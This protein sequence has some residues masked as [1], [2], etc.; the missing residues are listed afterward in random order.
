M[1]V[2]NRLQYTL[3]CLKSFSKQTYKD[4]EITIYDSGSTDGTYETISKIYPGIKLF[5]GDL[6]VWDNPGLSL[7]IDY[8]KSI[9]QPGDYILVQN[10]DTV[11]DPD[12]VQTLVT[13]SKS[14]NRSIVGA[15]TK[16]KNTGKVIFHVSKLIKHLYQ[17]IILTG[18][19]PE[20]IENVPT[21]PTRGT[22]FPIEVFHK[23]GNF[24]KL[25]PHY[26]G[27]NDLTCRAKKAGF[28]L[29]VSTKA[30]SYSQ[31]DNKNMSWTIKHKEKK[32]FKDVWNLFTSKRSSANLYYTSLFIIL[33]IPFP[34]NIFGLFR[35]WAYAI[36]FFFVDY[37][38]KSVIKK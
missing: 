14:Y 38:Y 3:E 26:G 27:D 2:R 23:I 17:H 1:A 34:H 12:F 8:V 22:I 6:N 7:C 31:D 16:S 24:S 5:K 33:D 19:V 21:L 36:K 25:F 28:K 13:T 29:L 35:I 4:I 11:M 9:A 20:V 10:D 18:D 32:T 30:V 37:L 15:I